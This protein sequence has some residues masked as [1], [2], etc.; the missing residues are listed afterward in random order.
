MSLLKV[1][2]LLDEVA[3]DNSKLVSIIDCVLQTLTDEGLAYKLRLPPA[4]VGIHMCNRDGYGISEGECHQLGLEIVQMGFSWAAVAHATAIE[5]CDQGL[6]SKHTMALCNASKQLGT[7]KAGTIKVGSLSCG[8]TNAFLV[9]AAQNAESSIEMISEGGRLCS[10][11]ICK[12]DS[13]MATAMTQGLE[14]LVL[15]AEVAVRFPQLAALIQQAKN[16]T[17]QSQR[18]E[19]E[20]QL[21]LQIQAIA[22]RLSKSGV[23]DWRAVKKEMSKGNVAK[24]I[25]LDALIAYV[26]RWGGEALLRDLQMF[27]Q[28]HAPP[29]RCIAASTFIALAS[30][31]LQTHEQCPLFVA[32]CL[33]TQLT[34]PSGK[35]VQRFCRFLTSGDLGSI[36]KNKL[37]QTLAAENILKNCR[38]AL[39]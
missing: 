21:L 29:S 35:V 33:K 4:F 9:A 15:K 37:K 38:A 10:N 19:G 7:Y 16:A 1:T 2:E 30:L 26:Q 3:S 13:A 5:D 20:L 34:C 23:A 32:A 27:H 8:H 6:I 28:A 22:N 24:H 39:Q 18:E 17:G 14:W 25:E 12:N 11:K 36:S 31:K